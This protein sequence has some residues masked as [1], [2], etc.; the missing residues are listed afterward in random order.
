VFRMRADG[1]TLAEIRAFLVEHGILLSY[2]GVQSMLR[3][4]LYLGEIHFGSYEP[5]LSAHPAIVD[6]ELW[7]RVQRVI[8]P[9]GRRAKSDRLLARLDVLRCA[10]CG[11]GM[12]VGTQTQ[13]RRSYPFYRCGRVREDCARRVTISA[14]LVEEIV[15]GEVRR[16]LAD[17]E[18]RAS[19]EQ[20]VREAHAALE[21]AQ[22]ELDA[23]FRAFAGFDAEG[24][25]ARFAELTA[26][27]D[28][29]QEQVDHLGSPSS[30][31]VLRADTDWDRLSLDARRAL[32]RATVAQVRVAPG[33]GAER[34]TVEL[35]GE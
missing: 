22:G 5:N 9:R 26:V 8:I 10:S 27:R 29:A 20:N 12:V 19:A 34:V 7:N 16:A 23:A 18:G 6:R 30:A 35:I 1:A 31:L 17:V 28:A 21:R 3:S 15:V 4:E 2:R 11:S 14:T 13:Q 32:I 24:A 25:R 33:R